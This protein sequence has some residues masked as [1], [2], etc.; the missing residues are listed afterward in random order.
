M[1]G[2]VFTVYT[3][4]ILYTDYSVCFVQCTGGAGGGRLGGS[5]DGVVGGGVGVL[6]LILY[7]QKP[8]K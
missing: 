1:I 5:V 6:D 4:Y 2:G 3:L 8:N 7:N